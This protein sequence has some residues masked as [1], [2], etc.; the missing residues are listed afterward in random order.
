MK[1]MILALTALVLAAGLKAQTV[2]G[3]LV[4][5]QNEAVEFANVVLLSLPDS[6]FVQGAVSD[7][8]GM[9]RMNTTI[10]QGLLRVSSIGYTTL[11]INY[12]GE[13][14]IGIQTLASDTQL[15]GEVTVKS[16][17]PKTQLKADAMV[18][19]VQNSVLEKAG[20][21]NDLLRRIPGLARS[22]ESIEVLGRGKPEI[23]INGRKVLDEAEL[24]Q[25]SSEN[26]K[27]VEVITNPGARYAAD[28]KAVVRIRTK[29]IKGEGLSI[30]NRTVVGY[31][32]KWD[33]L[34][35][36]NLT[37]KKNKIELLGTLSYENSYYWRKY[38]AQQNTYLA[39][40]WREDM[41]FGNSRRWQRYYGE[42][43]ANFLLSPDHTIGG[44]YRYTHRPDYDG[45]TYNTARMYQNGNLFEN[46]S[47]HTQGGN[48][49]NRHLGNIY[50]LG[51][52]GKWEIDFNADLLILNTHDHQNTLEQTVG[53]EQVSTDRTV[54]IR[55][56][57]KS[58]LYATKLTLTREALGGE[59]SLGGEYSY[60]KRTALNNNAEGIIPNSDTKVKEN[61]AAL[62][63]EFSRPIGK[64]MMQA[65]LRYEHVNFDYYEAGI[66]QDAQSKTYDNLFPSLMFMTQ[67]GKAQVMIGYSADITRPNFSVLSNT[68]KYVDRYTYEGGNPFLRPNINHSIIGRVSYKW[69]TMQ[70]GY[71]RVLDAIFDTSWQYDSESANI[72]YTTKTNARNYNQFMAMV[73]LAPSFGIW[74][75]QL[76]LMAMKQD[77]KADTPNG[78]LKL[79]KPMLQGSL[80]N[81]FKL[82]AGFLLTAGV[83]FMS[84]GNAE[85]MEMRKWAWNVNASLRK[86]FLNDRLTFLLQADDIFK[87]NGR[88]MMGYMGQVRTMWMND[89]ANGQKIT[90]TIR[91][92]FN[93]GKTK[94]KGTGAG[95]AAKQR[96]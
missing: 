53:N 28:V 23:Y 61:D 84:K 64:V 78:L 79:D 83:D 92:R 31:N 67:I 19:N 87:T 39:D 65:G 82:P 63:V 21:A 95:D 57:E 36:L 76:N 56:R 18:T 70:L 29:A 89:H 6:A 11:Y 77:Y 34:D 71:Q 96:L 58:N 62:F 60:V 27:N 24:D 81:S 93:T 73:N 16:E 20:T 14:N 45:D 30:D 48:R 2:E 8:Q 38:E 7:A 1:R 88:E 68:V 49:Y 10:K 74:S 75:P 47:L 15:L 3:K 25:L 54:T 22:G 86:G 37:Y 80:N 26:V 52:A 5:E 13:A 59:L 33:G 17:L 43:S 9:F 50:Y 90:L 55:S 66:H 51:K 44:K 4:N 40:N 12:A 35:Q 69:L 72:A 91:Y 41:N 42:L 85:T 46:M 94:Y 32:E